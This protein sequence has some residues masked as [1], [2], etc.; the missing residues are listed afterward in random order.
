MGIRIALIPGSFKPYHTG[1]DELVRLAAAENDVVHVYY[2]TSKRGEISGA[3]MKIVMEV[4]I[5][6]TFANSNVV[7]I[8]AKIT[9]VTSV[10]EELEAAEVEGSSDT[11][12][13]YSDAEDVLKYTPKKLEKSAPTLY[14]EGRAGTRGVERGVETTDVSGTLMRSYLETGDTVAFAAML[15]ASVRSKAHEIMNILKSPRSA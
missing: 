10:F 5:V 9:P 1:H 2:S 13:V 12:T 4:F 11:Y 14:K 6:P 15:P 3:S 7:F 8:E